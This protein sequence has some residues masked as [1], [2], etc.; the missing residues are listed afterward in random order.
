MPRYDVAIYAPEAAGLYEQ[1]PR[2]TGGAEV[3]TALLARALGRLGRRVAHVVFPLEQPGQ[4]P[5]GVDV[6][7]RGAWGGPG[8][9]GQLREVAE[10]WHALSRADA[11]VCI[12][13]MSSPV[14]G[15][16]ALHCRLHR[17]G[18][19]FAGANNFDFIFERMPGRTAQRLYA[20]GV[21]TARVVVVQTAEQA[22]LARQAFPGLRRLV[23]IPSF[24]EPAAKFA[25]EPLA[26]L[27]M[28]RFVDYKN[29]L[30]YVALAEALP[31]SNF[32]MIAVETG[33]TTPELSKELH[34]RAGR[35]A[36]LELLPPR[37][38]AEVGALLDEA[39]AV[40]ST[41]QLEGMPNVFLE[42]WARG[43]PALSLHFDPDGRIAAHGLGC[44]SEGS[45]ERFREDA[46]DLWRTRTNRA[47]LAVRVRDYIDRTHSLEAVGRRW[48]EVAA[49]AAT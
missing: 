13:R 36:N 44:A 1:V 30:D 15:V 42:G 41:S 29:P 27:W 48:A 39:V 12:F 2:E 38:R 3:Q 45:F 10:V 6:V 17:R 35:L 19:V 9:R 32:R 23:E 4:A 7:Q 24:A 37:G 49:E 25:R 14:L 43:V 21:R 11:R 31:E 33:E 34:E 47:A 5:P 26:F 22:E 28:G 16:V 20:F 46:A 40:V 8:A 18:L